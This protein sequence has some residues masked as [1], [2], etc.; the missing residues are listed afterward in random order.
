MTRYLLLFDC[1]SL[2]F[3]GAS[4]RQRGRDCLLYMLLPLAIAVFF[5][6]RIPWN[7][8]PYFT[9]S[10]LRLS[11]SSPPTTRRVTVEVFDP[12][13]SLVFTSSV[14]L[15][16]S[17]PSFGADP[18]ENTAYNS[19]SMVVMGGCL[20]IGRISFPRERVYREVSQRRQFV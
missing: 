6:V 15:G 16:S 7:S 14:G 9:L 3:C 12:A 17:L 1:Y 4:S 8:R 13:S 5:R 18:T 2:V 11:L 20:A 10:D 19:P